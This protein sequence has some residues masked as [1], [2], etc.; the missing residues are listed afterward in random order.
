MI[1]SS[2][3]APR[4]LSMGMRQWVD[5]FSVAAEFFGDATNYG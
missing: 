2:P 4:N 5:E 3:R 1:A